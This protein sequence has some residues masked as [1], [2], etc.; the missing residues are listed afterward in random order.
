MAEASW[1]FW[2]DRGGTFTDIV[3]LDPAGQRHV[4]KLLSENPHAYA[5]A[6][7]AGID[8]LMARQGAQGA[9]ANVKMGTTVATNALLERKGDATALVITAGFEDQLDIGTQARP[10]IFARQI[11]KPQTLYASVIGA[12]ERI[13]ADGGIE[14]PLDVTHLESELAAARGQGIEGVAIA[15]L[16]AYAFPE[17][18]RQ[19]A[20]I[21]RRLGFSQIS[22]SHE[23]SPLIRILPRA[24]TT[25]AD[26]YLTPVLRR[27]VD[28]VAGELG[29]GAPTARAPR[30]YFMTSA[31]GLTSEENFRGRDA[32]LSGP[33]GGVV[34][35][36]ETARR[37]GFERIIGFDMGGTSTDVAHFAGTYERTLETQIAGVRMAT[38]MLNIH[39]VAAGGGSILTFD[40]TRLRAGPESAGSNPGPLC[41]RRG[42]PLT[43]TDANVLVGKIMPEHFPSVFGANGDEALDANAVRAEFAA[44]ARKVGGHTPEELADSFLRIACETMAG[45]IKKISVERGYDVSTYV[46][47]CFGSAGGQHA[48]LIADILDMRAILIHPCSGVLSAYGMGLAPAR[49]SRQRSMESTFDADA[50]TRAKALA[51]EMVAQVREELVAQEMASDAIA[52]TTRLHL[53][54]AGSDTTLPVVLASR[55]EMRAAFEEMHKSR[56]GFLAPDKPLIIAALD[57]EA[58]AAPAHAEEDDTGPNASDQ[59]PR[60]ATLPHATAQTRFFARGEWHDAAVY[61][62]ADLSRG[63]R[64]SGPALLIEPNQTVVIEKGWQ[65]E[66]SVRNDLIMTRVAPR[67]RETLSTRPDPGLLE[68]FNNLFMGIAEQMG[69]AL[70]AT[71]QSVNIKERLDFSCAVFD[72]A[73]GL[74]SN[75]PHLPVHL[76]S[77]DRSV[78]SVIRACGSD[79]KPGDVY[80]LNAPYNG[81]T[82]LPDITVVTPVFDPSGKTI[83]FFVASR[84]HHEDVGGLTPGSMTPRATRIEEEGVLIDN[85]KLVD[86]GRFLEDEA[87]A[88]LSSGPYPARQ[89]DKN[90]ADLK[91]QVAANARGAHEIERMIAQYGLDVVQAYMGHVQDNAEESVRRLISKL[92]DGHF[93]V[94]TDQGTAVE[95]AITVDRDA[96]AAK[97]DFTGTSPQQANNFNAPEPVTRA[98]VLYVFR[99]MVDAPIPINAGCLRPLNIVIPDGSMLSPRYP[100]AVVAGNT[101]TSQV[102]T[103][104]LF[105]AL[106][107]LGSA[108]GTMNNLTFGNARVQYYET[109][110]SGAPAGLDKDGNGFDGAAAVHVHMTNTRLTDPEILE[111]RYPVLVE[112]FAI[113][114]GSGGKGRWHAGDG[115]RRVI[116]FLEQMDLAILSGFRKIRPFGLGG[117]EPG[118]VGRNLVRRTDG[119]LE[120][121]GG[122]AETKLAPGE[123]IIIET[124]TGGGFGAKSSGI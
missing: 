68:I 95:V 96:R 34:A 89:P 29:A 19:A 35:M 92:S 62:R 11:L 15:F 90:I 10:E 57:V 70:R 53:R 24:D 18:E 66:V 91:A 26:A 52:V 17:H 1:Q 118:Q 39:T 13:R 104:A 123:A 107:V 94:E 54:Y 121:I 14:T 86:A 45:A 2:I 103:N 76:G 21:A 88:L 106:G 73:G 77:M 12:R 109:I 59:A 97:I 4:L 7:L 31:G 6:A 58:I 8:T 110:C 49:A 42:G 124:P 41:Y 20:D 56:F 69:E 84:G 32:I 82:H 5:D 75:A 85:V 102:V 114:R 65:L 72:A 64:I 44:L 51:S 60:A 100:A 22:V 27:Y 38:P 116:R 74:V 117:G 23:I 93:R 120:D 61:M 81:G 67:Q 25:V 37:A 40:G 3:G 46:L 108:Q 87:R 80:M 55:D 71:A 36:A 105:G 98:A 48:C 115:I 83:L 111:L 33:A 122:C 112:A 101:E 50:L 28:R 9:L 30:L 99:V 47:N 79:L 43:V 119:H 113:R 16:H 63:D 78:E